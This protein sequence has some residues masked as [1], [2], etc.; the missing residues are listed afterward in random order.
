MPHRVSPSRAAPPFRPRFTLTLLYIAAIFLLYCML[1]ALPELIHVLRTTPP[2]PEQQELAREAAREAVRP[3]VLFAFLAAVGT[4]A[5]GAYT[6][7]L[8]G[9]GG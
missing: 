7:R 6:R 9:L 8:P 3:R 2:G 1:F 5:A 4:V